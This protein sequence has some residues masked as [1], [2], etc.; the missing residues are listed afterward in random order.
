M[1]TSIPCHGCQDGVDIL[2]QKYFGLNEAE[3]FSE[4]GDIQGRVRGFSMYTIQNELH[5]RGTQLEGRRALLL[6]L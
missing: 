4:D 6:I 1:K 3:D 5:K 2:I